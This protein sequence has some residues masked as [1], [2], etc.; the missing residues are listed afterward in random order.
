MGGYGTTQLSGGGGS[1]GGVGMSQGFG[2]AVGVGVGVA[3]AAVAVGWAGVAGTSDGAA[4]G[5][6]EVLAG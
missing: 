6:V 1:G 5:G 4:G 2:V 3:G